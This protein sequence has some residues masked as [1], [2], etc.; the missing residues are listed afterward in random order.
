MLLDGC[1]GC[2]LCIV[3]CAQ[4]SNCNQNSSEPLSGGETRAGAGCCRC[5]RS[6]VFPLLSLL[7]FPDVCFV[8]FAVLTKALWCGEYST[9]WG[10]GFK[11]GGGRSGWGLE[12]NLGT[13]ITKKNMI[14]H[15]LY[16]KP[17]Q[18][19][20]SSCIVPHIGIFFHSHRWR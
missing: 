15:N 4:F 5:G 18:Y 19:V 8:F 11:R 2:A 12:A 3:H 16:Y 20:R 17:R 7:G 9:D 14:V 13:R 10:L 6:R 1:H